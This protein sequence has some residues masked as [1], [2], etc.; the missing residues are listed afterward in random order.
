M[1]TIKNIT[2]AEVKKTLM[3]V[4]YKKILENLENSSFKEILKMILIVFATI[5][6]TFILTYPKEILNAFGV[7]FTRNNSIL[8]KAIISFLVFSNFSR[9]IEAIKNI[10]L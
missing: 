5:I 4:M 10:D 1:E 8:L 3:S 9:I 6:T 2:S 7:I